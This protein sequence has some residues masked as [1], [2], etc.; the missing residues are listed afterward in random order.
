MCIIIWFNILPEAVCV[1]AF[2]ICYSIEMCKAS[3]TMY[4]IVKEYFYKENYKFL[5]L[6]HTFC[7][8]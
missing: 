1:T 8:F 6:K 5:A 2:N 4:G 7:G 3:V